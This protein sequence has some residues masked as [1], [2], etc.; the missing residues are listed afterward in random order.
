[1]SKQGTYTKIIKLEVRDEERINLF[2]FT[3]SYTIYIICIK[4]YFTQIVLIFQ[5]QCFDYLPNNGCQLDE[6]RP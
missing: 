6:T 1:M 4:T 3:V 5:E 2:N